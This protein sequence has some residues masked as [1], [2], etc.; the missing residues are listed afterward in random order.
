MSVQYTTAHLRPTKSPENRPIPSLQFLTRTPYIER[1][2]SPAMAINARAINGSDPGAVPGTSTNP[3]A[4]QT[5][6]TARL[7]GVKQDRRTRKDVAFARHGSAVI[8]LIVHVPTIMKW[9]SLPN[10]AS[11][12]RGGTGQQKPLHFLHPSPCPQP[13]SIL[14][15]SRPPTG[16][17]AHLSASA[18]MAARISR[19]SCGVTGMGWSPRAAQ[20]V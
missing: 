7:M 2:G 11:A 5:L 20:V 1:A 9:Y 12:V 17:C 15:T 14:R 19:M 13:S 3:A 10:Q 18:S 16:V 4:G 8:G 6:A